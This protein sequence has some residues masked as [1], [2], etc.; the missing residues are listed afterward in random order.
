MLA[1]N[2]YYQGVVVAAVVENTSASDI[3]QKGDIITAVNNEKT[4][5]A[6]YLRY[7]L[8]KYEVGD[9]ITLTL[10]RNNKTITQ[11]VTLKGFN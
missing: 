10:I 11:K 8:Y 3:L 2:C 6:A 7:E 1:R 5:T 4:P 9:Q